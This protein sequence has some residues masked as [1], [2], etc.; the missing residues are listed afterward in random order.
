MLLLGLLFLLSM[1]AAPLLCEDEED[2]FAQT[3]LRDLPR[4][5]PLRNTARRPQPKKESDEEREQ[6]RE[7][8]QMSRAKHHE[9]GR[10]LRERRLA[11]PANKEDFLQK[12]MKEELAQAERLEEK[13]ARKE[14]EQQNEAQ[15][16]V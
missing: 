8:L 16:C 2:S 3:Q 15:R 14:L 6:R 13:I 1:H 7:K 9:R 11:R 5:G 4:R 12:K 10:S